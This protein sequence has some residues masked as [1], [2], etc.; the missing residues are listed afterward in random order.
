MHSCENPTQS[1]SLAIR[2]STH[3]GVTNYAAA[4]S[5]GVCSAVK[6]RSSGATLEECLTES[7]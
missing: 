6:A 7:D 2:E 1:P 3:N 5:R 4:V